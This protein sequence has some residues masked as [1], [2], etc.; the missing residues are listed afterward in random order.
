[1][2]IFVVIIGMVACLVVICQTFKIDRL[3]H[4]NFKL[5]AIA[6]Q[7]LKDTQ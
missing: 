3:E 2:C 7:A 1:M 5:K 4:E 6:Q